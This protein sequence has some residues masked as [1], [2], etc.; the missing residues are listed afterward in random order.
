[1]KNIRTSATNWP[2]FVVWSQK[3]EAWPHWIA[4]LALVSLSPRDADFHG[5]DVAQSVAR[6]ARN[7]FELRS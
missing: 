3:Y 2:K 4:R 7:A 6:D 1:M 5:L